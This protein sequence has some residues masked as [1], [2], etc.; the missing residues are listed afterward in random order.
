MIP[1]TLKMSAWGSSS[2]LR[3]GADAAF[4]A[5]AGSLGVTNWNN[6]GQE[7]KHLFRL[8]RDSVV[9]RSR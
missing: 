4:S 9:S 7:G 5:L 2:L 3:Y 6:Q 1:D 8:P